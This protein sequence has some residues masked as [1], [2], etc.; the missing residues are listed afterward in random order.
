MTFEGRLR[1]SCRER[2]AQQ[3]AGKSV[4]THL[5]GEPLDEAELV[6]AQTEK[7]RQQHRSRLE[8]NGVGER[9]SPQDSRDRV[10]T[11]LENQLMKPSLLR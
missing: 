7:I 6:E 10:H 5:A 2:E 1:G 8:G 4:H 11:L 9:R 3:P